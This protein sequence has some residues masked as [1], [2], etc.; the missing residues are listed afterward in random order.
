MST[1]LNTKKQNR[2]PKG[3]FEYLGDISNNNTKGIK[4]L[5]QKF[6]INT[7]FNAHQNLI[8]E[9]LSICGHHHNSRIFGTVEI[10]QNL[11]QDFLPYADSDLD[12][13]ASQGKWNNP[14]KH[15]GKRPIAALILMDKTYKNT[16]LDTIYV[17]IQLIA[18][19][20]HAETEKSQKNH[21]YI[22]NAANEVRSLVESENSLS[23]LGNFHES[24]KNIDY[25]NGL[26]KLIKYDQDIRSNPKAISIF[27]AISKILPLIP[28][29][30]V[31]NYKVTRYSPFRESDDVTNIIFS[32]PKIF[33]PEINSLDEPEEE[34]LVFIT[35]N[36][37]HTHNIAEEVISPEL[38]EELP[39]SDFEDLSASLK[40][41]EID[42]EQYQPAR[43][44]IVY[45]DN[46]FSQYSRNLHNPIERHWLSTALKD[47]KKLSSNNI[48]SL[49]ISLSICTSINYLDLLDQ[50]IGENSLITPD[51]Y[52][53]RKIPDISTAIKP[54][55][56]T[57]KLYTEHI[58][59]QPHPYVY[60]PLPD[61]VLEQINK[62]PAKQ[63]KQSKTIRDLFIGTNKEPAEQIKG[64]IQKLNN[65]YGQRFNANRISCQLKQFIK[66]TENDPC[67]TYAL[68]GHYEQKAPTAFYYRSITLGRLISIYESLSKQYFN[69]K[70]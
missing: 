33:L 53:R 6:E 62:I 40:D 69:A 45:L 56:K 48:T 61:I 4:D 20:I 60:L 58:S 52:F 41:I 63:L 18:L 19:A 57:E 54:G 10:Y 38:A 70:P 2:T 44:P 39:S 35:D 68:F 27:S 59:D 67:I 9:I 28:I 64:F 13:A 14:V 29:K 50:S 12:V 46:D 25:I 23:L 42:N 11:L 43:Y 32:T 37:D 31:S 24:I 16:Q 5:F 47:P 15:V 51:G 3:I 66:A 8:N 21:K 36:S 17:L 30:G 34:C 1:T 7:G 65:E 55:K 26:I 49:C 22:V